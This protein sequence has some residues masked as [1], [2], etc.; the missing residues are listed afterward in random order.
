MYVVKAK[1]NEKN[2]LV[3]LAHRNTQADGVDIGG[4]ERLPRQAKGMQEI[5]DT[6]EAENG[7][8]GVELPEQVIVP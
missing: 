3:S 5:E 2:A 4:G 7:R 1:R 8:Q 6:N